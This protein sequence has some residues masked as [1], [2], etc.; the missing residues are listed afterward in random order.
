LHTNDG[1]NATPFFEIHHKPHYFQPVQ[2]SLPLEEKLGEVSS[3][4]YTHVFIIAIS[5]WIFINSVVTF[6]GDKKGE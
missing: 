3:I 2:H 5:I 6:T 4:P 1:G